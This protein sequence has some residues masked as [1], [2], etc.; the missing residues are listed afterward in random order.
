L[1]GDTVNTTSRVAATADADKIVISSEAYE[2][3][4]MS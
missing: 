1:I 4:K 2:R 3:V